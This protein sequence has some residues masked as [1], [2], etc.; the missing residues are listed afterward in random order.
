MPLPHLQNSVAGVNK[1]DPVHNNIFEVRFTVPAGLRAKYSKDDVL[2]SQHITKVSGLNGL[3][4]APETATQKFM[5]TDRSYM[6]SNLDSTRC[7]IECTFTLNLRNDTENY[8]YN[9]FRD[10]AALGYDVNT[11]SRALKRDYCADWWKLSIANRAGDVYHEIIL[12]DVMMNGD[13]AGIDEYDYANGEAVEITV[14][15]VS[16]WWQETRVGM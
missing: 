15:F 16:D 14:K 9:Y 12:K 1:F 2:I 6:K 8:V 4:K 11:G 5:G 3:N 13:I 10:W 7:E